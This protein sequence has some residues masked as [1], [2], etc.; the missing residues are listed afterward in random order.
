VGDRSDLP[1]LSS[2][3]TPRP[4]GSIYSGFWSIAMKR[5]SLGLAALVLAAVGTVTVAQNIVVPPNR[6]AVLVAVPLDANVTFNGATTRASG[7]L[8]HF[9][10]ADLAPGTYTYTIEAVWMVNGKEV[11]QTRKVQVSPGRAAVVD[12]FVAESGS[13]KVE[14]KKEEPKKIET[15]KEEP[16][17]VETKKEEPKKVETKKEE[18]KKVETKKEEPKKIETKKE[19]PKKVETKKEEPKKIETKVEEPKKVIVEPKKTV[20][21]EKKIEPVKEAPKKVDV[22]K[23][24]TPPPPVKEE[25]KKVP[26]VKAEK[27]SAAPKTRSFEFV[28][29]GVLKQLTPGK[30]VKVWLPVADST[31]DQTVSVLSVK[32][33]GKHEFAKDSTYGNKILFF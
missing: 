2:S 29:S 23:V 1:P 16:K 33:P 15:K 19:E 26:A 27:S 7:S 22:P 32:V 11:K 18:P 28:Y 25:L 8:R 4:R 24:E 10:T 13:P 20:I 30:E 3:D 6:A 31:A 17:K 9:E 21:E 14:T 12:F 5:W